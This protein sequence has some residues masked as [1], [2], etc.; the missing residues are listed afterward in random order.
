MGSLTYLHSILSEGHYS[1]A[2]YYNIP[3]I[4]KQLPLDWCTAEAQALSTVRPSLGFIFSELLNREP[5]KH[6]REKSKITSKDI[7]FDTSR[8]TRWNQNSNTSMIFYSQ[9]GR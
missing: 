1:S 4:G 2:D 6:I 5:F 3:I 7:S 9:L 8:L